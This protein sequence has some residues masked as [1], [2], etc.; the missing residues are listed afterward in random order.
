MYAHC[1]IYVPF[2]KLFNV[3]LQFAIETEAFER[4]VITPVVQNKNK[5]L[6]DANN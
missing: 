2:K 5:S 6:N 3:I 4:R 1:T